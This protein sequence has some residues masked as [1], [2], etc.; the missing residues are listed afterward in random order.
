MTYITGKFQ[1]LQLLGRYRDKLGSGF[2]LKRF[3]DDLLANG[4]L[5][6]SIQTWILLDDPS[7][8]N[9]ALR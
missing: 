1:I 2:S 9:Q 3:Q 5:P 6:L 4:S 7:D 8:L